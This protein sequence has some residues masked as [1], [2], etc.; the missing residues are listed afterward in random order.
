[1]HPVRS[2]QPDLAG[3]IAIVTGAGRGIGA[4]IGRALAS[5]GAHVFLA[6]RTEADLQAVGEQIRSD[7][8]LATEAPTDL[9]SEEQIVSLFRLV[10]E[11]SG[12]LDILINNAGIGMYG[13]VA[14]FSAEDLDRMYQVNLRG[15]FLCSREAVRLMSPLG[16]GYI[17]SIASV[18]G[19][20]GYANQAGY[21]A[22]KHGVMGVTKSLAVEVQGTGIRVSA[23]LPGAVYTELVR[24]ARPDLDPAELLH[25]EDVAGAVLYLLSLSERAAVDAIYIRRRN[26]SPF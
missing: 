21:T 9:R 17:I 16:A 19:F 4:E 10:E 20:K 13:L 22:T 26:S 24:S 15:M 11:R 7:G 12:R 1:M 6:A 23:V 14:D 3:K 2:L 25:P 8:G 18:L 5:H